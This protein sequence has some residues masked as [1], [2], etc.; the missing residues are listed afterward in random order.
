MAFL[1]GMGRGITRSVQGTLGFFRGSVQELK[2]VRWPGRQEMISY[3]LV[4][5]LT[6]ALI[7]VFFAII[8]KGILMLVQS[9]TK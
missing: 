8:D 3:T 5:I 6:V 1:S 4:V 2:K 7:A 9:I